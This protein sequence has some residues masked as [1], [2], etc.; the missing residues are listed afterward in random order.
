[1]PDSIDQQLAVADVYAGALFELA[2]DAGAVDPIAAEL[3][4]LVKL[5]QADGSYREFLSSNAL[6]EEQRAASLEKM[7]RGRL[8]DMTLNTLLVM[9]RHGRSGL[10]GPLARRYTVRS[11]EAAGQ[12]EAIATTA[13]ELDAAQKKRI[14][15]AAA[16]ISG[17]KPVMEYR[18][19]PGVLAGAILQIGD[20]RYDNS[21]RRMIRAAGRRLA[22]RAERGIELHSQ[23]ANSE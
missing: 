22:E 10:I 17:K 11:E 6:A 15:R 23:V 9:N 8:S 20:V 16:E 18:V 7:F 3:A 21:A 4:E 12:I 13:V 2:R 1:M 19:E 14:E 5:Q